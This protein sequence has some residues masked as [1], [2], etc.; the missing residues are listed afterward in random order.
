MTQAAQLEPSIRSEW[1][2]TRLPNK[3]VHRLL[4]KADGMLHSVNME[5][6]QR[7]FFCTARKFQNEQ[8]EIVKRLS[9]NI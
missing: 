8:H 3:D 1:D 2:N 4:I 7:F 6:S 5:L 9:V